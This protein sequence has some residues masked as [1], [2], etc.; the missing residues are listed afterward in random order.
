MTSSFNRSRQYSVYSPSVIFLGSQTQQWDLEWY[1][2]TV[3]L[4]A[5]LQSWARGH[6]SWHFRCPI[7]WKNVPRIRKWYTLRVANLA[8]SSSC[9]CISAAE[10]NLRGKAISILRSMINPGLLSMSCPGPTLYCIII[11]A[12]VTFVTLILWWILSICALTL[13][14][15]TSDGGVE[16]GVVVFLNPNLEAY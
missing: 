13:F 9:Q 5:K 1:P 8:L 4:F 11:T 3:A 15:M 10:F 7:R 2:A 12:F 16:G 6:R 14:L